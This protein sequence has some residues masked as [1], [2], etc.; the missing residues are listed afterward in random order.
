MAVL[1]NKSGTKSV[2][3]DYFGL[4]VEADRKP[5]D[6][7]SAVSQCWKHVLAKHGNTLNLL[8]HIQMNHLALQSLAKAGI[9]GKGKHL[10]HKATPPASSQQTLQELVAMRVAYEQK[11]AKWKEL[12]DTFFYC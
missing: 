11:S 9:K 1:A 12:T 3:W 4:E 7:C 10:A 2:V 5:V 6:D 8:V